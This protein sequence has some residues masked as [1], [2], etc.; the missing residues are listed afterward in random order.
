MVA[1]GYEWKQLI[2][3]YLYEGE[4][5]LAYSLAAGCMLDA[6]SDKRASPG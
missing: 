1:E 2:N 4:V 3:H 6:I 5:P